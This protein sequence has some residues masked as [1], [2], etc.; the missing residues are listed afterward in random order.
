M[1]KAIIFDLDQTLVDRTETLK[2]FLDVQYRRFSSLGDVDQTG[3]LTHRKLWMAYWN[4]FL[5]A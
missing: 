3:F 4:R 1:L 5:M 2:R